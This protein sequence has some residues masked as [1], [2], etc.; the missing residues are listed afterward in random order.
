MFVEGSSYFAVNPFDAAH[1]NV[2]VIVRE[3]DL[4]ARKDDVDRFVRQRA[5]RLSGNPERFS[6]M[7]LDGKRIAVGPLAHA[8]RGLLAGPVLLAGDAAGFVDPFTGQGVFLALRAGIAAAQTVAHALKTP[9][10]ANGALQRYESTVIREMKQRERLARIVRTVVR[11]P[12]L[13]KRAARNLGRDPARA[14]SLIDA[15][16]G[17]GPVEDALRIGNIMKLVA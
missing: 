15:L 17:C 14:Q 5:E 9:A 13:S 3:N 10:E 2:M 4:A 12:L 1:A 7:H 8:T 16:A 6:N 11:S